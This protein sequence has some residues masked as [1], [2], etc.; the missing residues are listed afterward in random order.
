MKDLYLLRRALGR[1]ATMT[2]LRI[3][4]KGRH[5]PFLIIIVSDVSHRLVRN[6]C[7]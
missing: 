6:A 2:F 5:Q 4:N 1:S 3:N 7:T